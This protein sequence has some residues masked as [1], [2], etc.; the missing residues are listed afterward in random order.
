MALLTSAETY[1]SVLDRDAP[2]GQASLVVEIARL[3]AEG[4]TRVLVVCVSFDL[5]SEYTR[6]I[7]EMCSL[8][9]RGFLG[10]K[11]G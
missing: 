1:R 5:L 11:L 8:G 6:T 10:D 2:G 3:R 9:T 7:R 4:T